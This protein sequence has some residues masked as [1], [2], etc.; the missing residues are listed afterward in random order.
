L[1]ADS[2][3][4]AGDERRARKLA[5]ELEGRLA[6]VK[7]DVLTSA[8]A[9]TMHLT[10]QTAQAHSSLRSQIDARLSAIA[11]EEA[12]RQTALIAKLDA[13]AAVPPAPPPAPEDDPA[14]LARTAV[15]VREVADELFAEQAVRSAVD[16]LV[17]R[18]E[19]G[20][21]RRTDAR[22]RNDLW[23]MQAELKQA[24]EQIAR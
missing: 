3:R 2:T 24:R 15:L 4:A 7:K 10:Q 22:I 1:N 11:R 18:V 5:R 16:S 23:K 8:S 13:L 9:L 12:V 19:A 14:R 21:Q 6:V 20:E 17:D